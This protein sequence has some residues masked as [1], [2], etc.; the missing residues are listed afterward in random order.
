MH[1]LAFAGVDLHDLSIHAALNVC[2][3]ECGD[4]SQP[5]QIHG[6]V[7]PKHRSDRYRD[8]TRPGSRLRLLRFGITAAAAD[9][10]RANCRY[11]ANH[12]QPETPFRPA[13]YCIRLAH[14]L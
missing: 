10:Q 14:I 12:R 2:C 6:N 8:R 3:V 4:R 9:E 7:L 5:A 11:E 13:F 1:L